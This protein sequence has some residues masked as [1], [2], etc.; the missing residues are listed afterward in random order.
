L[1]LVVAFDVDGTLTPISSSW[2]FM[3]LMLNS[4]HRAKNNFRL[5]VDGLIS[6]DEWVYKEFSLWA[7]ISV[8]I[9]NKIL[10]YL[11]W[12]SGI[13]ELVR[14]RQ[15]YRNNALFVAVSG[16]FNLL[17]ERAVRELG[18]NDYITVVPKT[19]NG[20]LTGY[21]EQYIDLNGKGEALMEY[22]RRHLGGEEPRFICIG[23]NINDVEMFKICN[24]S[25]A[26]CFN[27]KLYKYKYIDV[28]LN[29][30]NIRNLAKLLD[31]VIIA[32]ANK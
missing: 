25:I 10:L 17:G 7:G 31:K 6:Y 20:V 1:V 24:F 12:R 30:C 14:V 19:C 27:K 32:L 5:F 28:F 22:A 8:D 29:T 16:G 15:K 9:F 2:S 18:F 26:F 21:V 3:H 11:P 13:E 4:Q 23:D